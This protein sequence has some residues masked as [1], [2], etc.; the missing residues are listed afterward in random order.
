MEREVIRGY[1]RSRKE[2]KK[3]GFWFE[4]DILFHSSRDIYIYHPK[5][6]KAVSVPC[7]IFMEAEGNPNKIF[8]F[9]YRRTIDEGTER[10]REIWRCG[11]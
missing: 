9:T 11:S 7:D 5:S 2:L 4:P 1:L 10:E 6:K 3:M 8:D